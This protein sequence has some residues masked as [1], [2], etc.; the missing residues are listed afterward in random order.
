[1]GFGEWTRRLTP[2]RATQF[3][4]DVVDG[5]AEVTGSAGVFAFY[6]LRARLSRAA[7]T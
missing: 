7:G 5:Y 6:Q 2:E 3:V 1:V 4:D